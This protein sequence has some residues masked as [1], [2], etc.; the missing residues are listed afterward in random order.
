M[1][2]NVRINNIT[3]S[4]FRSLAFFDK[5]KLHLAFT[6]ILLQPAWLLACE[7]PIRYFQ[8]DVRYAYRIELL[9]L[10]LE[11]TQQQFGS[12]CLSPISEQVTPKRGIMLLQQ[13]IKVDIASLPTNETL[14]QNLLP[15]KIPILNGILGFRLLLI[16]N[17]EQPQFKDIENLTQFSSKFVAGFNS[18]WTDIAI[19]K[20]NNIKVVATPLYENL[21]TMLAKDRFDY[22][23]R[24]LNEIYSEN[25]LHPELA[26]DK[27][28]VLHYPYPV[29]FF[30]NKSNVSLARRIRSG[31]E[32]IKSDGSFDALFN[33][34][35]QDLLHRA[36]LD[37]RVMLE[38]EN[39]YLPLITPPK[40]EHRKTGAH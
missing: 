24:G 11:K 21:F 30:V 10:I 14:E 19:L 33:R 25:A 38:L 5:M 28:L 37:S 31:L 16:K 20:T 36:N 17:D 2:S 23:P 15:I 40:K 18:H 1:V 39:P 8:S 12:Y 9:T 3:R 35:H 32:I 6:L 29:Y 26:I 7:N 13:G 27:Y 34:H 4:R 22:F